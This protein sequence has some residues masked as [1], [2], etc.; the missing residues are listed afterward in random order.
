M[1][2]WS[3]PKRQAGDSASIRTL[4]SASARNRSEQRHLRLLRG[5]RAELGRVEGR[6]LVEAELAADAVETLPQEI[7]VRATAAEAVVKAAVVQL[8]RAGF[9][10]QRQNAPGAVRHVLLEPGGEHLAQFERQAQQHVPAR[11][12]TRFVRGFQ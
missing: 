12:R 9:A 4:S 8:A 6:A 10:D 1:E 5:R 7:G 3:F 11:S 2:R